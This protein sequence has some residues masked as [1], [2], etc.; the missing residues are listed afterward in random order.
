[1]VKALE[2]MIEKVRKHPSDRQ[3]YLAGVMEEVI[4]ESD[5]VYQLS[6]E[7]S[8]ITDVGLADIEAGR[9]VSDADM[10][11]FWNRQGS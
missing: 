4:A 9:I 8:E 3:E 2:L 5:G 10:V 11:A 7:E 1:M 6:A